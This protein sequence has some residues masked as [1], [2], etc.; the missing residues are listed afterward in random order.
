MRR[1][2]APIALGRFQPRPHG[3]V[4]GPLTLNPS[5]LSHTNE[6]VYKIIDR[7]PLL[8]PFLCHDPDRHR[9]SSPRQ[10]GSLTRR[11][12]NG[13][14]PRLL[15]KEVR[16]AADPLMRRQE[17]DDYRPRATAPRTAAALSPSPTGNHRP[18][19]GAV[20]PVW[21]RRTLAL[22][23]RR[24]LVVRIV[25]RCFKIGVLHVLTIAACICS[26]LRYNSYSA[27]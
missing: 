22:A 14:L 20:S 15:A 25:R 27:G 3:L 26:H 8:L 18:S 9:P 1:C 4:A 23:A 11:A 13:S 24:A 17:R 10:C 2:T 6:R 12:R 21:T 7:L 19:G 16:E 5:L